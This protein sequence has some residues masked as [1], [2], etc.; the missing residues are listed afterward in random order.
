MT[1]INNAYINALLADVAYV[2]D[3][4]GNGVIDAAQFVD[5]NSDGLSDN[6][7]QVNTE[8]GVDQLIQ[9]MASIT[10]SNSDGVDPLIAQQNES[11]TVIAAPEV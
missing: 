10:D 6:V 1:G 4:D 11:Q 5:V 3:L 2:N 9:S 7:A 8:V